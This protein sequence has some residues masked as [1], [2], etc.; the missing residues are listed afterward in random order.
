MKTTQFAFA[1]LIALCSGMLHANTST[2]YFNGDILTMQGDT[3]QYVEAVVVQNDKIIFAG[4]KAQALIQAGAN[5]TEQ[6][7]KGRTLMPG[8][9]DNWGHFTLVAQNTLGVNL[10]Y[11]AQNPPKTKSD[12]INKLRTEGK[13]FNG[14]ILSSGYSEAMLSDGGLTLADLDRAF[15]DQPVLIQNI[16]TLTGQVNSA[17]LKKLGITKATKAVSGFI[18]VDP[19]TGE[20]TGELIGMPYLDAVVRAVGTYSEEITFDTYRKAEQV[21]V[22]NGFTT[23]Q[24]YESTVDDINKMR[25]AIQEKVVSLD[26]IALPTYD[27]VD[28]LLKTNPSFQ[29]GTYSN[30]D[31]GFKV[32]GIMV[33]TDGAPQLRLAYF[34]KPFL[35]GGSFG[36]DWRGFPYNPQSMV[37]HYVK[38][39]YEKNI[40][41]FGYSNGDAGIDMTLAA[42]S[43]AIKETGVTE[44]RRTVI[45]HSFFAREDQLKQYHDQN[46]IAVTLANHVW[47]YGDVYLKI[48]GEDRAKNVSP[49]R[50]ADNLGVKIGIHN[51]SPS[52][53]PNVLFSVW[54]A[55]NR[56]TFSGKIL[57]ADQRIDAYKA[58]KGF[59]ANAAYVYKEEA[60]KGMIAQGML[61]DLVVLDR[62]PLKVPPQDIKDIRVLQTIKHGQSVYI[63]Q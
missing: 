10:G 62:N 2:L 24:S 25:K 44:N 39:A 57:G 43:K 36:K 32:A 22:S 4:D 3:P 12:A 59:T 52:S 29:F 51:D 40:Q 53:G 47:L 28:E 45:S 11:F 58:L 18:P 20:L 21:Y 37:D 31:R 5:P 35:D 8:F 61:A 42:I 16:S 15:P 17:G 38:L 50:S 49:L 23:A 9:I 63:N 41:Y 26:L 1:S 33:P 56:K 60:N 19:K 13:P 14:W 27:V 7:L 54:G 48:L 30:S 6:D 55:V 46:I 34:T